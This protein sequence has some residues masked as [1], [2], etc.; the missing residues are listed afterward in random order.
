VDPGSINERVMECSVQV[1]DRCLQRRRRLSLGSDSRLPDAEV[2]VQ[3]LSGALEP[4]A[5][6]RN[7]NTLRS[8]RLVAPK[9][10]CVAVETG[11]V[12]MS[13]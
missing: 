12:C 5:Q 8:G 10:G 1:R 11:L 4:G 2:R 7:A 3:D 9:M 6:A 13:C